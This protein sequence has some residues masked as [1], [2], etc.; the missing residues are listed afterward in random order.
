MPT[1]GSAVLKQIGGGIIHTQT[2]TSSVAVEARSADF[3]TRAYMYT[4]IS[5]DIVN[6][7]GLHGRWQ[8]ASTSLRHCGGRE[9]C[10]ARKDVK[11]RE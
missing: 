6:V 1:L 9:G 8:T 10:G 2:Q 5:V 7:A 3:I 4:C 11:E